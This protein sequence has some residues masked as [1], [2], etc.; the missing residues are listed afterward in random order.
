MLKKKW[1]KLAFTSLM[2]LCN[3]ITRETKRDD[4]EIDKTMKKISFD[5]IIRS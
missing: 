3:Q 1:I 5:F 2:K 4:I